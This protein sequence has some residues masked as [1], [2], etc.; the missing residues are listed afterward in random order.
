MLNDNGNCEEEDYKEVNE[1]KLKEDEQLLTNINTFF[2]QL[3]NF[4]DIKNKIIILDINE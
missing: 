3:V 1:D 4:T 2:P